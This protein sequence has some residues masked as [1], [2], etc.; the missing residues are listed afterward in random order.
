M[1]Y[2]KEKETNKV[3]NNRILENE[4]RASKLLKQKEELIKKLDQK[5]KEISRKL[6]YS[7]QITKT[8]LKDDTK[9]RNSLETENQNLKI[10]IADLKKNSFNGLNSLEKDEKIFSDQTLKTSN[11]S[12]STFIST[13]VQTDSASSPK[14]NDLNSNYEILPSF[15]NNLAHI[16]SLINTPNDNPM[17]QSLK[18]TAEEVENQMLESCRAGR[19]DSSEVFCRKREKTTSSF[20]RDREQTLEKMRNRIKELESIINS[21][22]SREK[23]PKSILR[24][25]EGDS[26]HRHRSRGPSL[27]PS[28]RCIQFKLEE[29]TNPIKMKLIEVIKE[30]DENRP[31]FMDSSSLNIVEKK[32]QS[33]L[34]PLSKRALSIMLPPPPPPPP[35]FSNLGN[36]TI[37][38]NQPPESTKAKK[39]PK[40]PMKQICWTTLNSDNLKDTVWENI[41]ENEVLFDL[42]DVEK[43]FTSNRPKK[44]PEENKQNN[45]IA[46]NQKITLLS[47]NR[48]K[49]ISIA[50][51]KLKMS[52]SAISDA[53]IKMDEGVLKLNTIASLLE[54]CPKEDELSILNA[55]EGDRSKLDLPEQFVLEMK[56]VPGFRIRLEAMQFYLTYKELIEDF[57]L[58]IEKLTDLFENILGDEDLRLLLKYI[59]ALGNYFNGVGVRGG[60]YGFKLDVFDK[61]VD[62]KSCDGKK[63]FLH[64]LIEL[65]EK[66]IGK[67]FVDCNSNEDLKQYEIGRKLPISQLVA[68]LSDIKKGYNLVQEAMQ[69]KS[70]NPFDNIEHYFKDFIFILNYN[71]EELKEMLD[72]LTNLYKDICEYYC[73]DYDETPSDVFVEK[74]YKIWVACKKAKSNI[75]KERE[76]MKKEEIRLKKLEEKNKSKNN[77]KIKISHLILLVQNHKLECPEELANYIQTR[78]MIRRNGIF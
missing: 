19:I 13:A 58:K 55:Y 25:N 9:L 66:N 8:P 14:Y 75:I 1:S 17:I 38:I 72:N 57:S 69:T 74:I 21:I 47:I 59:L 27:I 29:E 36:F 33:P 48:S 31:S 56:N 6:S 32:E 76:T 64:Y 54:A 37:A 22:P 49:N 68:D 2:G 16:H 78:R 67:S 39:I 40:V 7:P 18:K 10:Q 50:L 61:I 43:M 26:T 45:P 28:S 52:L 53:V 4:L 44:K 30:D 62:M 42:E 11:I 46:L 23:S 77:S 20:H 34:N 70:D 5:I 35:L 24:V 63:S 51:T 3:L 71:I 65:I 12:I 15:N 60:A 73:E 41:N